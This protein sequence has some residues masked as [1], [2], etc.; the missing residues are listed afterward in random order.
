[1]KPRSKIKYML[2]LD[3]TIFSVVLSIYMCANIQNLWRSADFSER[4]P[5]ETVD[6]VN[7]L[8]YD[9]VLL[10]YS[11]MLCYMQLLTFIRKC[12]R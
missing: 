4:L 9:T 11:V 1:M 10:S 3:A 12:Y 8:H 6:F 7:I 5:R 2:T